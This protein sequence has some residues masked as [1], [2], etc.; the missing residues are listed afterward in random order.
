MLQIDIPGYKILQIE[1]VVCDYNGTLAIDGQLI[2]GIRKKLQLLSKQVTIHVITADTFENAEKQLIDIPCKIQILPLEKQAELK[3][4]YVLNI[5][6]QKTVCIG[7]GRN[8]LLMFK[9]CLLG[10]ALILNEGSAAQT[11]LNADIIQTS[12]IDALNLFLYPRRLIA[13]LR[14]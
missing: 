9:E 7:N 8:D 2:P 6:P 14:S 11:V 13:T 10:I 12:I 5:G 1:H 3:Q 4:A